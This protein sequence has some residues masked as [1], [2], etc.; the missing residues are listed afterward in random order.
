M[1][2][3]IFALVQL[4]V[5]LIFNVL[6]QNK[7]TENGENLISVQPQISAHSQGP[8]MPRVLNQINTAPNRV[9]G[10]PSEYELG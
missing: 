9:F 5:L 3:L 10:I 4:H 1:N 6:L 7:P 8:K 2:S